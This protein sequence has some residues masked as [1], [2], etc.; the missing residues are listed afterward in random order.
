M[1]QSHEYWSVWYPK[2][3]STGLLLA[4]GLID[5]T[6]TLLLHAA[7]DVIT[8]E[9]ADEHGQRVAFG[10]DLQRTQDSPICRLRR[11]GAIITREDVWPSDN[12]RGLLVMLPGGEVGTLI[13]WWHAEDKSEWR[14]QVEFYNSTK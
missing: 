2:A 11:E 1:G 9:V 4:R 7:G 5:T 6:D 12:D 14:W 10:Q 13:S 8:V 3:A